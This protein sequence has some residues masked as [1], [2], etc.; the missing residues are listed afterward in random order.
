MPRYVY[1]VE[2]WDDKRCQWMPLRFDC[3]DLKE[4][5]ETIDLLERAL[6]QSEFKPAQYTVDEFRVIRSFG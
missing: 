3:R 6:P 4:V 2:K 5:E 1:G